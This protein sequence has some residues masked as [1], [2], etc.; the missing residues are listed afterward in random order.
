MSGRD[1][2]A[3]LFDK[4]GTLIDFDA[5]WKPVYLQTVQTLA[6]GN[7]ALSR[8]LLEAGGWDFA[9]GTVRA[10]SPLRQASN[11][12]IAALWAKEMKYPG[13]VETLEF[14]IDVLFRTG[15]VQ[16]AKPTTPHLPELLVRLKRANLRIGVASMDGEA[17]VRA[18]LERLDLSPFIDFVAGYD[19]GHGVKPEPGMA[20]AFASQCAIKPAQ[21]AVVGDSPH[22]LAMGRAAGAGLVI[23]FTG[24]G[25]VRELLAPSADHIV[26]RLEDFSALIQA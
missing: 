24:S 10:G 6:G 2:R 17:A 19:S 26:E 13:R 1:I 4:D 5:T 23:G 11:A 15:G 20:L 12:Q 16:H 3:V 8:R 14:Q 7:E 25:G 18:T 22:D 9:S 21:L